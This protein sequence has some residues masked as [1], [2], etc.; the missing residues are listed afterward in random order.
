MTKITM[1]VLPQHPNA[2]FKKAKT[3]FVNIYKFDVLHI[4]CDTDQL[5][6]IHLNVIQ[7]MIG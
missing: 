4:S 2:S 7:K 6:R 1:W 5:L 3:F